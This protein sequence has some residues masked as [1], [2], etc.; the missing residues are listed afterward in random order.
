MEMTKIPITDLIPQRPPFVLVD[1]L[2][3]FEPLAATTEFLVRPDCILCENG[4]LSEA[5]M[6]ENFAQTCATYI[7]YR[8]RTQP[9][10]IGVI[11]AVKNM[12][13]IKLVPIG[14]TIATS[15]SIVADVFEMLLVNANMRVD[16]EL[17]STC[18]MK[19]SLID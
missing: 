7:G 15:I 18:E 16:G 11:G 10:K 13:V 2:L 8:N 1:R 6:A 3:E 9:V 4:N 17:V 12:E 19:I 5:G 14:S